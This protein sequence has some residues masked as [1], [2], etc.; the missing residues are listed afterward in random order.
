MYR[1]A[2]SETRSAEIHTLLPH[3]AHCRNLRLS[4]II[5]AEKQIEKLIFVQEDI[6]MVHI[7]KAKE[8]DRKN[9]A[10]CIAEGFE[11]LF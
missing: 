11:I 7:R 2:C 8:T 3:P 1:S 6:K 4:C 5:E 9:V 10:L